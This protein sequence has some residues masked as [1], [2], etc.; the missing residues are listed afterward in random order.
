M[1]NITLLIPPGMGRFDHPDAASGDAEPV[2]R[3]WHDAGG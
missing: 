1:S 3:F 2:K